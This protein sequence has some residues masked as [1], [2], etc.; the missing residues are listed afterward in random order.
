[1]AGLLVGV[2]L[3]LLQAGVGQRFVTMTRISLGDLP[4]P[5]RSVLVKVTFFCWRHFR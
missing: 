5:V 3:F 4:V 2:G 1:M